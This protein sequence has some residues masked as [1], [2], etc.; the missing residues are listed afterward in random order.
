MAD[1]Y[2][3]NDFPVSGCVEEGSAPAGPSSSTPIIRERTKPLH[4]VNLNNSGI[5]R[6]LFDECIYFIIVLGLWKFFLGAYN[7][8]KTLS[9]ERS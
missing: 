1:R 6:A 4:V 3:D 2:A 9:F 7:S 8:R 5:L